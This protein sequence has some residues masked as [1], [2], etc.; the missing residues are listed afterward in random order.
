MYAMSATVGG[1]W[2]NEHLILDS[3]TQ[4]QDNLTPQLLLTII[5]LLT[6]SSYVFQREKNDEDQLHSDEFE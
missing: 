3:V 5:L 2:R 4:K 6:F 1:R